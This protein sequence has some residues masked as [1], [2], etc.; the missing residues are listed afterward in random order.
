MGGRH[1]GMR[2]P[3]RWSRTVPYASETYVVDG[4]VAAVGRATPLTRSATQSPPLRLTTS[5]GGSPPW[6]A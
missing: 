2:N 4:R 1:P 3:V 6:D 5:M